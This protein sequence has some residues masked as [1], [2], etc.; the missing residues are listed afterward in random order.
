[1]GRAEGRDEP[2]EHAGENGEG[3]GE[4][5]GP[6]IPAELQE[7]GVVNG[8]EEGD[9]AAAQ[10]LSEHGADSAADDGQQQAFREQLP[11]EAPAG[12]SDGEPDGEFALAN[13]ST[14]QEEIGEVG[15]GDQQHQS[16]NGHEQPQGPLVFAAQIRFASGGFT[17]AEFV[18]EIVPDVIGPG[19]RA[20]RGLHDGGGKRVKLGGGSLRSEEDTSELQ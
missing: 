16:G 19:S 9:Q 5:E 3:R 6:P 13:A 8:V 1:M 15:A 2:E 17:G 20:Q 14:R 4:A 10:D 18:L 7:Y 11:D 12:G